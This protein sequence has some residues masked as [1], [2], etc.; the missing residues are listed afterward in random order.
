KMIQFLLNHFLVFSLQSPSNN[1]SNF[2]SIAV[3]WTLYSVL[4]KAA[5][6]KRT[7]PPF[8]ADKTTPRTQENA[9]PLSFWEQNLYQFLRENLVQPL[10]VTK[11][12]LLYRRT[13]PKLI[14]LFWLFDATDA[15]QFSNELMHFAVATRLAA[16]QQDLG[17]S[18]NSVLQVQNHTVQIFWEQEPTRRW[19]LYAQWLVDRTPYCSAP[20]ITLAAG[21]MIAPEQWID[22][23]ALGKWMQQLELAAYNRSYIFQEF[24]RTLQTLEWWEQDGAYGRL[25]D[26]VYWAWHNH[27]ARASTAYNMAEATG[28]MLIAPET[29]LAR[30]W[31][32]ETFAEQIKAERMAIYRITRD[33]IGRAIDRGQSADNIFHALSTVIPTPLPDNVRMNITDWFHQLNRHQFISMTVIHSET[34]DDSQLVERALGALALQRW[35]DCDVIVPRNA[36]SEAYNALQRAGIALRATVHAL[37][38]PTGQGMPI[39]SDQQLDDLLDAA[40]MQHIIAVSYY[41]SPQAMQP[42]TV[43]LQA[44]DLTETHLEG[45]LLGNSRQSIKIAINTIANVQVV[46]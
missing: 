1:G 24:L 14:K 28:E 31:A 16:V 8:V 15:V 9:S 36:V 39:L 10:P 32:L 18:S 12:G 17:G 27:I 2:L 38:D 46:P 37:S 29:P 6:E 11:E 43:R 44:L 30:R 3:P 35:S 22:T 26:D 33:S 7:P 23:Q 34:P 25:R 19:S 42:T 41:S 21:L 45:I 20:I 4:L 13:I 5:M 40:M